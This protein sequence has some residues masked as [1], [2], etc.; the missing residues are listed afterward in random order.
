MDAALWQRVQEVFADTI[1][2]PVDA[3][4]AHLAAACAGNP[5]LRAEVES[6]L[7]AHGRAGAFIEPVPDHIG[8]YRLE[9]EIAQGGMGTVYRATRD[10]G[11]FR[12]QVAVKILSLAATPSLYRRF[13]DEQQ[14]LANLSHANIARLLDGGIT[15]SGLSYIVMEFIEGE[16]IDR[17][18]GSRP[19]ARAPSPV[20]H[21]LCGGPPRPPE[22]D[23]AP[24]PQAGE[25]SRD[26]GRCPEAA[27]FRHREDAVTGSAAVGRHD[28]PGDDAGI[29]EPR[30]DSR[31]ARVDGQRRLL[32]RQHPLRAADRPAPVPPRGK[33]VRR[34]PPR[35]VRSAD[36][37]AGDRLVGSRCDR[38]QGHAE[39]ARRSLSVGRSAVR[40]HRALPLDAPGRCAARREVVR[41]VE[42]RAS[43]PRRR[44]DS[45]GRRR[46]ARHRRGD[47][48]LPVTPGPAPLRGRAAAGE[49]GHVRHP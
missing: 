34:D 17:Y 11:Q 4:P 22:P 21:G 43:P 7:Q 49:L 44:G 28:R 36:R 33:D 10:D 46:A 40:R 12:H 5:D 31:R 18:C 26:R 8:A 19:V 45:N 29:C 48:P 41:V 27:R 37:E 2:L 24:R 42:V 23:R 13:L 16:P 39:G 14:I 20:P 38:V 32:A 15:R 35:G 25:H 47:D 6:L 30:A 9:E 3:R 1:E